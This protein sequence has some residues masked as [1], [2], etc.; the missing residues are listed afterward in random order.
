MQAECL[1]YAL[2]YDERFG[3]WGGTSQRDRRRLKHHQAVSQPGPAPLPA[4][5][6][7]LVELG[8]ARPVSA[9]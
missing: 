9:R 5:L 8:Y 2:D 6:D 1:A 7:E 3:V 4:L